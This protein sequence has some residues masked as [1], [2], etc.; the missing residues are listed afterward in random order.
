MST[1]ASLIRERLSA[2][3][4]Y[5]AWEEANVRALQLADPDARLAWLEEAYE[6]ALGAGAVR[7]LPTDE[8]ALREKVSGIQLMHERLAVLNGHG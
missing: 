5:N 1:E 6:L 4:R 7:P 8:A 3:A 2:L